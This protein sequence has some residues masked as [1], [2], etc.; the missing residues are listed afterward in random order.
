MSEH[1]YRG[2]ERYFTEQLTGK[3][4]ISGYPM[5]YQRKSTIRQAHYSASL[6]DM[7]VDIPTTTSEYYLQQWYETLIDED[8]EPRTGKLSADEI[9]HIVGKK[10]QL[11]GFSFIFC[12][13]FDL[14]VLDGLIPRCKELF[15]TEFC[16]FFV[17]IYISCI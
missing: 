10:I 1:N 7:T 4:V 6:I 3:N 2:Y 12:E 17:K 13:R 8:F 9:H 11:K 16:I 15:V 14:V 5:P